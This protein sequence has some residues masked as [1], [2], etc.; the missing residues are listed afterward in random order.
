MQKTIQIIILGFSVFVFFLGNLFNVV[1]SIPTFQKL[2]VGNS[3][4]EFQ[5]ISLELREAVEGAEESGQ[6]IEN[7]IDVD[8]TARDLKRRN[9]A[10]DNIVVSLPDGRILLRLNDIGVERP[11]PPRREPDFS[12]RGE[13]AGAEPAAARPELMNGYYHALSPIR[14]AKNQMAGMVD[15]IVREETVL[16]RGHELIQWSLKRMAAFTLIASLFMVAALLIW[17]DYQVIRI[18][19]RNIC[20]ILY[21]FLTCSQLLYS[22]YTVAVIESEKISDLVNKRVESSAAPAAE[23][24]DAGPRVDS[25]R[26]FQYARTVCAVIWKELNVMIADA[27]TILVITFIFATELIVFLFILVDKFQKKHMKHVEISETDRRQSINSY[28]LIR[29]DAFIFCFAI[30]LSVSFLPLYSKE[31]YTPI[32]GLSRDFVIGLPISSTMICACIAFITAGA[33]IDKYGWRKCHFRG[34]LFAGV[35]LFLSGIATTSA[36]FILYQGVIGFGYGLTFIS[37]MAFVY[38][39]TNRRQQTIGFSVMS[40]GMFSGS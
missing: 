31:L 14:N 24:S 17:V 26:G 27:L 34:V 7:R 11:G 5:A 33:W 36:G 29:P 37:Y 21:L 32:W 18:P 19:K 4:S 6:S 30:D 9:P 13:T 23:S 12:E 8:K 15:V 20:I 10:V 35:G 40:A 16:K 2:S 25:G 28:S 3:L 22:G 39:A 38:A 1:L